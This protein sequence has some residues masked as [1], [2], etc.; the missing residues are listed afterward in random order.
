MAAAS[1]STAESFLEGRGRRQAVMYVSDISSSAAASQRLA[2]EQHRVALQ[3]AAMDAGG[4]KSAPEQTKPEH[5]ARPRKR[6][7][8][9]SENEKWGPLHPSSVSPCDVPSLAGRTGRRRGLAQVVA[10][11]SLASGEGSIVTE[12]NKA[13]LLLKNTELGKQVN[14]NLVAIVDSFSCAI[15]GLSALPATAPGVEEDFLISVRRDTCTAAA[16]L[17]VPR[18]VM[19]ADIPVVRADEWPGAKALWALVHSHVAK[20]PSPYAWTETTQLA[21]TAHK[22]NLEL[23]TL[24]SLAPHFATSSAGRKWLQAVNSASATAL[25]PRSLWTLGMQHAARLLAAKPCPAH[26]LDPHVLLDLQASQARGAG[27]RFAV[28]RSMDSDKPRV[29]AFMGVYR[30]E[31]EDPPSAQCVDGTP[32]TPA[33]GS[34]SPAAHGWGEED[35]ADLA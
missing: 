28:P 25:T 6:G 12:P 15:L 35:D 33:G 2:A 4:A 3:R 31:P 9:G 24:P 22:W 18:G 14:L 30:C 21:A 20:T 16:G 1:R 26:A 5:P 32:V 10:A 19:V 17:G 29:S 34:P 23:G 27:L 13:W 8:N 7:R 11:S